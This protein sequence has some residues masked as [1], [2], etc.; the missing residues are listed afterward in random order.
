MN[1][2]QQM[3]RWQQVLV[4]AG[5]A[6]AYLAVF[7]GWQMVVYTVYSTS[8]AME[9]MMQGLYDQLATQI[10]WLLLSKVSEISLISGLLTLGTL[11]LAFKLRRRSPLGEVWLR[12]APGAVLGWG[13]GLAFCL[14]WLV[15]LVLA[16]LPESWMSSYVD[17]SAS[18]E[19]VSVMAFLSTAL[20]APVV[21]E[22]VFRGLIYTRLQRAMDARW[23]VVVSAAVFG[24]CHGE[25]VWFCYAFVL[26]LIFAQLTRHT[27]S[28][29]PS[30]VMH[31]VFNAT[32][33]LVS[34]VFPEG[35]GIAVFLVILLLATG[36]TAF[37]AIQ[38]RAAVIQMPRSGAQPEPAKAPEGHRTPARPVQAQRPTGEPREEAPR[39]PR[40]QGAA[41]DEDSGPNHRFPPGVV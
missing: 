36:G 37:C 26:G 20:V 8:I 4:A 19:E 9:L 1:G 13:A 16:Y 22:V 39:S 38:V 15:T 30:M 27:G 40:T 17:A 5:K 3:P 21:E 7:L 35:I 23:A 34:L 2:Q 25:L 11:A 24:A 41:W 33:Q 18:L 28:I 14:Y 29:L 10:Y 6:V 12:R 31:V 32:G